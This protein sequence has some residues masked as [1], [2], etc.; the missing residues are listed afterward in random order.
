MLTPEELESLLDRVAE[1]VAMRVLAGNHNSNGHADHWLT[2]EQAAEKLNVS[3]KWIYRHARKW[4][5][6]ERLSRKQLRISDSGL[7]RWLAARTL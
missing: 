1:R 5:F 3:T 7:R 6:V 4:R 2:P